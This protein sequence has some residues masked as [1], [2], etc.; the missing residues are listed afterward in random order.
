MQKKRKNH[1][2][3]AAM[4]EDRE[5]CYTISDI[6]LIDPYIVGFLSRHI[7]TLSNHGSS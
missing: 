4:S 3:E 6:Y 5:S 7:S 2:D 1:R